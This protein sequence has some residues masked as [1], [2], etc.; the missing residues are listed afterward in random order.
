MISKKKNFL[1]NFTWIFDLSRSNFKVKLHLVAH[2]N[3]IC[4]ERNG[5]TLSLSSGLIDKISFDKYHN[6][7]VRKVLDILSRSEHFRLD[8]NSCTS[9]SIDSK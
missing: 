4:F 3:I 1:T 2:V 6:I 5:N 9:G 7:E 8:R